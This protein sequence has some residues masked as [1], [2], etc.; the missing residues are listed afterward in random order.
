MAKRREIKRRL[1]IIRVKGRSRSG[2]YGSYYQLNRTS[3]VKMLHERVSS[4]K[5]LKFPLSLLRSV[6]NEFRLLKRAAKK[7]LAP[8]PR[9]IC[10]V[11]RN[12]KFGLGIVQQHLGNTRLADLPH[13]NHDFIA[14]DLYRKL[15]KLK[16]EHC[17]LHNENVMFR[18]G[19]YYAIDFGEA[20][21]L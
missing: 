10:L 13:I 18:R 8:K 12:K 16:I 14:D 1:K 15:R 20:R 17:D 19:R 6:E 21:G 5:N 2:V 11:E 9:Y 7:K 3:G 4:M